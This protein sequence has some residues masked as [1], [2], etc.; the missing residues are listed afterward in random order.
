M[1][2]EGFPDDFDFNTEEIIT[3]CIA[4]VGLVVFCFCCCLLY[5]SDAGR[6]RSR[7]LTSPFGG[8]EGDDVYSNA[9]DGLKKKVVIR[10]DIEKSGLGLLNKE[11]GCR[12]FVANDE[13]R[14][15]LPPKNRQWTPV[16]EELEPRPT[17]LSR[18]GRNVGKIPVDDGSHSSRESRSSRGKGR[19]AVV[20]DEAPRRKMVSNPMSTAMGMEGVEDL[21]TERA[22]P[23]VVRVVES[24]RPLSSGNRHGTAR[25]AAEREGERRSSRPSA[26]RTAINHASNGSADERPGQSLASHGRRGQGMTAEAADSSR[27]SR[28][29]PVQPERR[30]GAAAADSSPSETW[31]TYL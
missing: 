30:R 23:A 20:A 8:F 19:K 21:K 22:G 4:A 27:P 28:G 1:M 17:V 2:F 25:A 29:R 6:G 9:A 12:G 14:A 11:A 24:S 18:G 5:C 31:G 26:A 7:A 13:Q 3:I 16:I 15:K 10:P